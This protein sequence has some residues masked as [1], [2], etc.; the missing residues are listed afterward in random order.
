MGRFSEVL[1]VLYWIFCVGFVNGIGVNLGTQASHPLSPSIVVQML[2]DNGI[3][4]LKL[5]GAEEG[6]LNALKNTGIQVMVG[7]QNDMLPGLAA[8][9][10]AAEIWVSKNVSSYVNDGV[11]IS[12]VAVGNEPF[13]KTLNGTYLQSTFPALQ[14]IQSA[15]IKAGLGNQVKATIP[16]NADVYESVTGKPS[17]GDFRADIKD[18]MLSIVKFLNDNSSPFTVNIY[19]F[20]SLLNDPNF[21]VDYAF[22]DGSSSPIIDGSTTYSNT[23]D[24]NHDT[25]VSALKKNGFSN[26]SIIV[27]EIGWPTD[28]NI[29][30]N[31]QYAQ[32]FNQ[33]LMNHIGQGTPMRPG[34]LDVYLFSLIDEDEKSIQPG[35]FERHWGIFTFDGRTKYQLK[36][37]NT[38]LVSAKG[39]KYLEKRWCV[40]KPSASLSDPNVA[41]SVSFACGNADCTSLGYKTSCSDLDARGNI[42][43]AFNSYYQKND[44]DDR[45]CGFSNLGTITN[46]DPSTQT[47]KFPIMIEES[48]GVTWRPGGAQEHGY[49]TVLSVLISLL[50]LIL[51]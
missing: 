26:I 45:A 40:L 38:E 43:Y 29:N 5:F 41:S 34:T 47:C 28:G 16:L 23:L 27:G 46:Q 1:V 3:E 44:Q 21:P 25:L 8:D 24:A 17:D 37:G 6:T 15:L 10:N 36:I 9:M 31:V 7:I 35:N 19:P 50:L 12:Y 51:V 2:K 11:N 4:K 18:L 32:K 42:S 14:N 20:I 13:L 48:R 30:A 49:A 22:F 33:G 39:V